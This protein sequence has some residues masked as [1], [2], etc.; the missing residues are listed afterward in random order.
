MKGFRVNC[1]KE[2]NAFIILTPSD[3]YATHP[4]SPAADMESSKVTGKK[5]Q[6][7]HLEF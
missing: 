3:G 4:R 5:E 6:K 1:T 2:R 7:K